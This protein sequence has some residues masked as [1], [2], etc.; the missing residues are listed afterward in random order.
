M[1]RHEEQFARNFIRKSKRERY[2]EL[3]GSAKGRAKIINQ[4]DHLGDLDESAATLVLAGAQTVD[5]IWQMLVE[6]GSPEKIY[7]ISSNPAID[8]REMPLRGALQETIG[9]G[10]G[11]YISCI[12]GR[13]GYFESGEAGERYILENR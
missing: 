5:R 11:T 12:P 10:C 9:S 1:D 3:F 4:L 7:V 13:L 2:L 6:K 8:G